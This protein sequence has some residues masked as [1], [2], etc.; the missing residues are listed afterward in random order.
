MPDILYPTQ[1]VRGDDG[2]CYYFRKIEEG[3][4]KRIIFYKNNAEKVCETKMIKEL[5]KKE[6]HIIRFVK[7][8]EC[9]F[10]EL[11]EYQEAQHVL[12]TITVKG[13]K[14][15]IL[16]QDVNLLE[17]VIFYG[18]HIYCSHAGTIFIY[19]MNGEKIEKMELEETTLER[20][21]RVQCIV[22]NK[23][24]Y[25]Y[26]EREDV[27]ETEIKRCDLDG[28]N[29]EILFKSKRV[30]TDSVEVG[31]KIDDNYIYIRAFL[32]RYS[33]VRFPLYGGK[34]EGITKSLKFELSEDSI[35]YIGGKK[36]YIYQVDKELKTKP[37]PVVKITS[38]DF[39]YVN[40]YLMV[41]KSNTREEDILSAVEEY[42]EV[43]RDYYA[44]DYYWTTVSGDIVKRMPGS[45]LKQ[46]DLDLYEI[47]KD[48]E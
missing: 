7:Y 14:W 46:E 29:K 34:V 43:D 9:F 11:F 44:R 40:G 2:D 41:E 37:K 48:Y 24:Y 25:F 1:V 42:D 35:Y 17:K 45:G 39:W 47:I 23:I 18:D 16:N 3:D 5:E 36:E 33:L 20:I 38:S 12:A 6:Y 15:N 4:D 31:L 26:T 28:S 30:A 21:A 19:N 13:G 32:G 27:G 10:V 22:D 8:G